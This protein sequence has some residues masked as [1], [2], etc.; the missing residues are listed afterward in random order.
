MAF[1]FMPA[2][3]WLLESELCLLAHLPWPP[4]CL[5]STHLKDFAL[6]ISP[7]DKEHGCSFTW[8][9]WINPRMLFLTTDYVNWAVYPVFF[10]PMWR[11]IYAVFFSSSFPVVKAHILIKKKEKYWKLPVS[12]SDIN[13][14]RIFLF[15]LLL[16]STQH[17]HILS[18]CQVLI[19]W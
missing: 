5:P 15:F 12:S 8:L 2:S 11:H 14:R 18:S 19:S 13:H 4:P 9:H 1:L 6:L 10:P 7:S 16:S 17:V 3:I